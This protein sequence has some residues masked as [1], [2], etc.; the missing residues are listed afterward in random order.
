MVSSRL[1]E[2]RLYKSGRAGKSF[3]TKGSKGYPEAVLQYSGR[4]N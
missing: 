1:M 4:K 3:T 2:N